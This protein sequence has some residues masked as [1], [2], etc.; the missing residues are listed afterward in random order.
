M[1]DHYMRFVG[2]NTYNRLIWTNGMNG[3]KLQ[4]NNTSKQQKRLFGFINKAHVD[5]CDLV[6]QQDIHKWFLNINS[7]NMKR[8]REINKKYIIA[9]L[10]LINNMFG[11]GLP[12]TC[13]YSTVYGKKTEIDYIYG[14]YAQMFFA[15]KINTHIIHHLI[16]LCFPHVTAV[17]IALSKNGKI[18]MFNINIGTF[19]IDDKAYLCAWRSRCGS[20]HASAQKS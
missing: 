3:S 12:T 6:K 17:L 5:K 10:K 8:N 7:L 4:C 16:S 15:I 2:Y 14:S 20:K 1:N 18:L 11:I 9:E 13:G 19:D